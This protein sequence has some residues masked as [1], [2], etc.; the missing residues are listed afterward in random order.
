[1]RESFIYLHTLNGFN[2]HIYKISKGK[3]GLVQLSPN[4][5][6][7]LFKLN[8]HIYKINMDRYKRS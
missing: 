5:F 8:V 2:V 6:T 3:Y 4:M 1:M 7:A